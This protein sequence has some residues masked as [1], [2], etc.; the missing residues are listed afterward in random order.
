MFSQIAF[1]LKNE[2]N[3][4]SVA[5]LN[6]RTTSSVESMNSHM[7]RTFPK[8]PNIFKFINCLKQFEYTKTTNMRI[9]TENCPACQTKRKHYKDREREKKIQHFSVLLGR[10]KIDIGMFL[11]AMSNERILPL[12]GKDY[13]CY[14]C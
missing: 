11:E 4:L 14:H 8:H 1:Y 9:L 5:N 10:K 13:Y 12:N 3:G 6:M 2:K 7:G